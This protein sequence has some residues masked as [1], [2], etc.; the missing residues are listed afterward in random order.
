MREEED[1]RRE[2]EIRRRAENAERWGVWER[3]CLMARWGNERYKAGF[4]R[5]RS[6]PSLVSRIL[7]HFWW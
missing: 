3:E 6:E 2:R 4:L 1:A 7:V 5:A